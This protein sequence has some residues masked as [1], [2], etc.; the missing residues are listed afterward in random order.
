MALKPFRL[1]LADNKI[2]P[3]VIV[4]PNG[5]LPGLTEKLGLP[6]Y[7]GSIAV[8]GG[9]AGFDTPEFKKVK[10]GVTLLLVELGDFASQENLVV[11]DG[12]TTA[13]FMRILG[14]VCALRSY[15]FTLIGIAPLGKV[16]W[17][18]RKH[19]WSEW[20][21]MLL[22]FLDFDPG[23]LEEKTLLDPN[24][25]AFVLVKTDDWGG[26][27]EALAEATY[28]LAH[29]QPS[30]EVLVNGGKISRR[31]VEVYLKRGGNLIVLEGSG[32]F[33]DETRQ[34]LSCRA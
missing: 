32:R 18:G 27:V 19:T 7:Q 14:E 30:V 33:A 20:L 12:G 22:L 5:K 29:N 21:Q 26:E 16:T 6:Q 4:P 25:T 13:G 9:A 2:V 15:D 1:N 31:D 8:V 23:P 11:T 3:A 24:H 34:R 28:E 10:E 17:N